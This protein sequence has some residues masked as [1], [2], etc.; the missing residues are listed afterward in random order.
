M[1]RTRTYS[2]RDTR[3]AMVWIGVA[4][5]CVVAIVTLY[6]QAQIRAQAIDGISSASKAIVQPQQ[7]QPSCYDGGNPIYDAANCVVPTSP[8]TE[9]TQGQRANGEA[10]KWIKANCV[11]HERSG[12]QC[13]S[14]HVLGIRDGN[15][16]IV[17]SEDDSF[18][19]VYSPMTGETDMYAK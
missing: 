5:A 7:A 12:F 1:V 18:Y 8:A 14:A 4:I 15:L 13:G 17:K 19:Y 9:T 10:S 16:M 11:P 6:N 2:Y 3:I